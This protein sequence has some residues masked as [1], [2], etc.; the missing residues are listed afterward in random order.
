VN[1]DKKTDFCSVRNKILV[2]HCAPRYFFVP[3]GTTHLILRTYGTLAIEMFP[4]ST[5]ILCLTA[6]KKRVNQLQRVYTLFLCVKM[7]EQT[8]DKGYYKQFKNQID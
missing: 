2:E 5:N 3:S 6:S 8:P 7:N 4:F 1:N